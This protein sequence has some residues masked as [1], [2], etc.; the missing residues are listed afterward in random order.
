MKK[1]KYLWI[2]SMTNTK[3]ISS[4]EYLWIKDIDI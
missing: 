2:K 4:N 1:K 3:W